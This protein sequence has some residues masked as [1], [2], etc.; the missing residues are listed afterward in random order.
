MMSKKN[1][2]SLFIILFM[3]IS[4]ASLSAGGGRIV[5]FP[6]FA[7]PG[8]VSGEWD[9]ALFLVPDMIKINLMES[10]RFSIV[11]TGE[12][13]EAADALGLEDWYIQDGD[14]CAGAAEYL[15]T[16]YYIR[17]YLY[18]D[19]QQLMVVHTVVSAAEGKVLH[20]QKQKLPEGRQMLQLLEDSSEMFA[21][22]LNKE[23]PDTKPEVVV[24]ERET[25]IENEKIVEV[26]VEVTVEVPVVV[27]AER[28]DFQ[29]SAGTGYHFYQAGSS[30]YLE[31]NLSFNLEFQFQHPDWKIFS[32]GFCLL[33]EALNE[34]DAFYAYSEQDIDVVL[35]PFLLEGRFSLPLNSVVG[36]EGGLGLGG[37]LIFGFVEPDVF[38]SFRP[39]VAADAG[40]VLFPSSMI[41]IGLSGGFSATFYAY[42]QIHLFTVYPAVNIEFNF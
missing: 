6:Y 41:S 26:P 2:I 15:D 14:L 10:Q 31:P 3:F 28:V 21:E 30:Q 35:I 20:I 7:A 38:A 1:S 32:T 8:E 40:L 18:S 33:F 27:E 22:W 37:A 24:I 23:L 29:L 5:V 12:I 17:G 9:Y 34:K 13:D 19:E 39:S 36:L 25:I 16:D 42:E 4:A 11:E